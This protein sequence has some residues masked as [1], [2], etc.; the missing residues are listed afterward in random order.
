[1]KLLHKKTI[2]H[3]TAQSITE[4]ERRERLI[5]LR[6]SQFETAKVGRIESAF[7]SEPRCHW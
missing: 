7:Q 4:G 1:M 6:G 2:F 5:W 3:G